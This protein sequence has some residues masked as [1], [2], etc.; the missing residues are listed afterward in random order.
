[1]KKKQS[2]KSANDFGSACSRL[3]E[4]VIKVAFHPAC[5]QWAQTQLLGV[6]YDISNECNNPDDAR[7]QFDVRYAFEQLANAQLAK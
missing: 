4:E 1:M 5:P 3:S 6:C 7:L 2:G